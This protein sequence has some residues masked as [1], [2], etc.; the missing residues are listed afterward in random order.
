MVDRE[1]IIKNNPNTP[2]T[3]SELTLYLDKKRATKEPAIS[4]HN[5]WLIIKKFISLFVA[6]N[7]RIKLTIKRKEK[8]KTNLFSFL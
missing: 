1:K 4:S 6:V 2:L 5:L 7:E 3:L 8:K